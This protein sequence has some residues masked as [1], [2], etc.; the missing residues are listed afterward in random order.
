MHVDM[1]LDI[2]FITQ[3][4][5]KKI[6]MVQMLHNYRFVRLIAYFPIAKLSFL[7]QKIVEVEKK[8]KG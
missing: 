4:F 8:E 6:R 5:V 7:P 3:S 1:I 2:L